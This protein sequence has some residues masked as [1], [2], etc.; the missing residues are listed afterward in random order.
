ML[1][2]AATLLPDGAPTRISEGDIASLLRDA[3]TGGPRELSEFL[4]AA[5]CVL[6]SLVRCKLAGGWAE[7][8]IDDVVQNATL[9]LL[10]GFPSC[11]ADTVAGVHAWL[12][13]IARRETATL[14]RGEARRVRLTDPLE[15]A[16]GA[17]QN[18]SLP[19]PAPLLLRQFLDALPAHQHRLLWLRLQ[20]SASWREVG[21]EM[22]VPASAAK[23]RYQRLLHRARGVDL[24]DVCELIFDK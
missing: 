4:R 2:R 5:R 10:R 7:S 18:G 16:E 21:A 23:R 17:A 22:G 9:D 12:R 14:F 24:A 19:P 11:R 13:T 8:W 1:P 20:L 6:R 15:A 3:Q